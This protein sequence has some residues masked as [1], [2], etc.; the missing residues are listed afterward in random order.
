MNRTSRHNDGALA[1]ALVAS[2]ANREPELGR[3]GVLVDPY[4]QRGADWAELVEVIDG[5]VHFVGPRPGGLVVPR[6]HRLHG[7]DLGA[8]AKPA[9][10]FKSVF[11][12]TPMTELAGSSYYTMRAGRSTARRLMYLER[13]AASPSYWAEVQRE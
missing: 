5:E 11:Q 10:D 13:R 1:K 3:A 9:Q 8:V 2:L 12:R 6:F 7:Q 4:Q